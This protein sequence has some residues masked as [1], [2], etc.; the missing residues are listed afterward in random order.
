VRDRH[1]VFLEQRAVG[2]KP[3]VLMLATLLATTSICRSS[4]SC[5]DSLGNDVHNQAHAALFEFLVERLEV[6]SVPSSGFK[7]LGSITS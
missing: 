1:Q 2:L 3:V 6:G 5:R 7:W 4:V